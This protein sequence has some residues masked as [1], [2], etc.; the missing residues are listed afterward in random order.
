MTTCTTCRREYDESDE[1]TVREHTEPVHCSQ[2]CRCVGRPRCYT[3]HGS[4][5]FCVEH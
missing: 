3:C 2:S 4:F 5:C 1:T